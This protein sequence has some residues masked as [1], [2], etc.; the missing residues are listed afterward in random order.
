VKA[1]EGISPEAATQ[2]KQLYMNGEP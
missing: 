2:F 1:L